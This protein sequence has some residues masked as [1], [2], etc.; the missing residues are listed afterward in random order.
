[1]TANELA[2][3]ERHKGEA[4]EGRDSTPMST[5]N[6]GS[7]RKRKA[8]ST[9]PTPSEKANTMPQGQDDFFPRFVVQ[10][11]PLFGNSV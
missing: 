9:T 1:L 3:I 2:K 6:A 11:K 10:A 7:G 4:E 5:T 8:D